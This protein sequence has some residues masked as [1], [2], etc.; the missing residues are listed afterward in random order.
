MLQSQYGREAIKN[1]YTAAGLNVT[2]GVPEP[3]NRGYDNYT[4]GAA[5]IG[6]FNT[7]MNPTGALFTKIFYG[8]C[9]WGFTNDNIGVTNHVAYCRYYHDLAGLSYAFT[10]NVC[11]QL[12][13][14]VTFFDYR[15]GITQ[16]ILVQQA[17]LSSKSQLSFE[18]YIYPVS[19]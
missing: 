17:G 13:S 19:L 10:L 3:F 16:P 12:D 4:G 18:G 8:F 14:A 11:A 1:M 2:V 6:N 9:T 7:L 15:Q 5:G